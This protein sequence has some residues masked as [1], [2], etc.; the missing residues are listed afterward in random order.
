[1]SLTYRVQKKGEKGSFLEKGSFQ[2]SRFSRDSREFRDSQGQKSAQGILHLRNPNLG[3][4]SG[5]RILDARILDP[6]SWVEFIDSV[7]FQQRRPP[8]KFTLEKFTFQDSPSKIQP[9]IRAKKFTLHLCRAIWLRDSREFRNSRD[10]QSLQTVA[11]KGE[12]DYPVT[13]NVYIVVFIFS[14]INLA[15]RSLYRKYFS[16]EIILLY[17]TLS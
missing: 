17:V 10:L 2:E 12:S 13:G 16:A 8:E 7:L 1:M 9:R 14:G 3:P 5:K 6:N 4:N 15:L 11:N